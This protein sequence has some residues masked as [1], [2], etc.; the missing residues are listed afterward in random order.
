MK[1]QS[2]S[3]LLVL[4]GF[5]LSLKVLGQN[6]AIDVP[7]PKNADPSAHV[8]SDGNMYVYTTFNGN[9]WMVYSSQDLVIWKGK[10]IGFSLEDTKWAKARAWAPD[11]IEKNG[12]YYFYYPGNYS[13]DTKGMQTGVAVGDSPTGPFKEALGEPLLRNAHDPAIFMDDDGT[14]YLYAQFQVV[15]L[16][17]DMVSLAEEVKEVELIGHDVPDKREAVF[18]FKRDSVYYWTLA[19]NFNTLT[20]W[21]GPSP[22]GPFTYRGRI[23]DPYDPKG[24]NN[25]HS[26]VRY[27]GHWLLFY[28]RWMQMQDGT[29]GRRTCIDELFFNPDGSIQKINPSNEGVSFTK[30]HP[31]KRLLT[32]LWYEDEEYVG[33][34]FAHMISEDYGRLYYSISTDGLNFERLNGG[35]RINEDYRGHPFIT[36]GHDGRYYLIGGG[37]PITFWVSDDLV[38][39]EKYSEAKPDVFRTPDFHPGVDNRGAAKLFWDSQNQVYIVTW[40][41]SK[42]PRRRNFQGIDEVYWGGQRALY[43]LSPDLKTFTDPRLLFPANDVSALDIFVTRLGSKYYT[44]F[45]DE[46]YPSYEHPMGKSIRISSSDQLTGQYGE[47]GP[48]VSP[49][50]REAPCIVP[51]L[52][53]TGYYM[54]FER[55]PGNGYE[56]ATSSN[57]EDTWHMIYKEETFFEDNTRHGC[58]FPVTKAQYDAIMNAYGN[59]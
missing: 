41:T 37:T 2:I 18:V 58:V 44:I 49:S 32:E 29:D 33:Y 19:E 1:F 57:P 27:H 54:Y 14:C 43:A 11:C 28:H 16:N 46:E 20:Y 48:A 42:S 52:D 4:L 10:E 51:R 59:K 55:Y 38:T 24:R 25:H 50:F 12:K 40:Q 30:Q 22:Y 45:K 3:A 9:T 13:G 5:L 15:K 21:T 17:E 23:M 53:H 26:V 6:P 39:W 7:H 31:P 34:V 35:K 36:H 8:W 56:I 47:P